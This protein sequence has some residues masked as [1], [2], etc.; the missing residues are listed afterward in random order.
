MSEAYINYLQDNIKGYHLLD[1]SILNEANWKIITEMTMKHH[2]VIG[3]DRW[4][5]KT[6]KIGPTMNLSFYRLTNACDNV[7]D[8]VKEIDEVRSPSSDMLYFVLLKKED[9][10]QYRYQFFIIPHNLPMFQAKNYKWNPTFGKKGKYKGIQNGWQGNIDSATSM[11]KMK[12]SFGTTYQLWYHL[13]VSELSDYKVC[14]FVI[15]KPAS[16][17]TYGDIF[18]LSKQSLT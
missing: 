2:K 18:N 15:E 6:S 8:I 5:T 10:L 13:K 14:E 7:K 1:N 3:R 12:I 11:A 17:L 16:T 4:Q 9:K